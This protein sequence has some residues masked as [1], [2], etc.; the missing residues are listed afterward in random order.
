MLRT[1]M[2]VARLKHFEVCT[3]GATIASP[4][5]RPPSVRGYAAE[6]SVYLRHLVAGDTSV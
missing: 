2:E 4:L 3:Y 6:S 5:S 1:V